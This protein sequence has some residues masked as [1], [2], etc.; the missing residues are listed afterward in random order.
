MQHNNML[1]NFSLNIIIILMYQPVRQNSRW[2]SQLR[3]DSY[4]HGLA[5]SDNDN[6]YIVIIIIVTL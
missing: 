2:P 3:W 6:R 1:H 5:P 4:T